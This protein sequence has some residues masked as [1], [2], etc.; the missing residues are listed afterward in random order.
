MRAPRATPRPRSRER[1][2]RL[3]SARAVVRHSPPGGSS[4]RVAASCSLELPSVMPS[5]SGQ[6]VQGHPGGRRRRQGALPGILPPH[7]S[8][9]DRRLLQR[10][11]RGGL[12]ARRRAVVPRHR[13]CHAPARSSRRYRAVRARGAA[14]STLR[15]ARCRVWHGPDATCHQLART[16]PDAAPP[17]RRSVAGVRRARGRGCAIVG[18]LTLAVENAEALPWADA[19]FD[20]AD[21]RVP[22]P[23]AAARHAVRNA[24]R[25]ML[26]VVKPGSLVVLE[27]SAQL[28]RQPRARGRVAQLPARVSSRCCNRLLFGDDLAEILRETGFVVK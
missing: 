2:G 17:R 19:T 24:V 9:A 7:V 5:A 8:L 14:R 1:R 10:S 15:A 13:R 18:E 11:L 20:V 26:R 6:R 27:R 16:A 3:L 21:E 28:A 12:R 22:V 4:A 23:R 25:E